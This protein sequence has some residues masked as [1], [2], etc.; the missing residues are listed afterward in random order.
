MAKAE[1]A[2][3]EALAVRRRL[4]EANPDA[5]LPDVATTLNGLTYLYL[6]NGQID[7]AK[8]SGSEAEQ[9]LDP[10]WQENPEVH[11]NRMARTLWTRARIAEAAKAPASEACALAR[12]ALAAAYDSALKES[13]QQLIDRLCPEV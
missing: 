13:I 2:Y 1:E 6:S 4:A 9:I 3:N 10:L 5:Y 8:A 11:G 7:E 12:R